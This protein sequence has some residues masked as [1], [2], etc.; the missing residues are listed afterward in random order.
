[1]QEHYRPPLGSNDQNFW[2]QIQRY[3]FDSRRY[4]I[5]WTASV[6]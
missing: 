3:G 4:Q 5:L 1:M 2:L 6:V